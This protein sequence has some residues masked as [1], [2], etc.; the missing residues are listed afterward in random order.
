[1]FT[2]SPKVVIVRVDDVTPRGN[3]PPS[4][5]VV[6]RSIRSYNS[7]RG[8]HLILFSAGENRQYRDVTYLKSGSVEGSHGSLPRLGLNDI[9][10]QTVRLNL[11]VA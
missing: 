7:P 1:M 6:R 2:G 9:Y 11:S 5:V 3:P 8:K 10:R 4:T